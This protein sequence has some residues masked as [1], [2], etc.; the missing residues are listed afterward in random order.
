MHSQVDPPE[1]A[2]ETKIH[3]FEV[4]VSAILAPG[5]L[6]AGSVVQPAT[7]LQ[8]FNPATGKEIGECPECERHQLDEAVSAA[9]AAFKTWSVTS[10]ET[11][12]NLVPRLAEVL[13][14][15]KDRLAGVLVLEQGKPL[16]SALGEISAAQNYCRAFADMTLPAE[17]IEDTTPASVDGPAGPVRRR[18]ERRYR[19]QTVQIRIRG[20][21]GHFC[22]ERQKS[23]NPR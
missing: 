11:R 20:L 21:Y 18:Q 1:N 13:Q 15:N 9:R 5:I 6:I 23:P 22:L 17:I 3:R 7:L 2:F 14:S 8:V 12:K 4:A 10:R 16:A 19:R